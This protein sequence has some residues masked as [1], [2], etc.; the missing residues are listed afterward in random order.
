MARDWRIVGVKGNSVRVRSGSMTVD[1][2]IEFGARGRLRVAKPAGVWFDE[3]VM[4]E[5][6]AVAIHAYQESAHASA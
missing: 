5:L 6:I 4:R 2:Q 1:L 3:S